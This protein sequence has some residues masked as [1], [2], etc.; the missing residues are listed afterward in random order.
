[1]TATSSHEVTN[2]KK[3]KS[4]FHVLDMRAWI[5][6]HQQYSLF[7]T[8]KLS[9]RERLLGAPDDAKPRLR[10]R[11]EIIAKYRKAEVFLT[12]VLVYQIFSYEKQA[13]K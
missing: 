3:G 10:T 1:M 6:I 9:E 4:D 7:I 13:L 5:L 8:E 12:M 2:T 11:E